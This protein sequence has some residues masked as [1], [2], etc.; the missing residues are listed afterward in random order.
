MGSIGLKEI[1]ATHDV[2]FVDLKGFY[3]MSFSILPHLVSTFHQPSGSAD[4]AESSDNLTKLGALPVWDLTDLY[5]SPQDPAID[6]DLHKARTLAQ[7]FETDYA[8]KLAI[9]G[10][11]K[12]ATALSLYE[13]ISERIDKVASFSQLCHAKQSDNAEIGAFYQKISEQSTDIWSH[14]LFFRLEINQLPEDVL[15]ALLEN[16]KVQAYRPWIEDVRLFRS[17]DLSPELEKLLM[18][19]NI[20]GAQAWVRL[21]DEHMAQLRFDFKGAQL[22]EAE[23]LNKLSSPEPETRKLAAYSLGKT[24][25]DHQH[26]FVRIYNSLIKD[27]AVEDNWRGYKRPVSSRNMANAVEDEVVD[28]LVT[29]VTNAYP[30][31]SHR[32]YRLKAKWFGQ[33]K[34]NYWDRNAP[35]PEADERLI[36][37]QDATKI[38]TTAYEEFSPKLADIAAPFFQNGWIDAPAIPGKASGA[39]AH[40]TVPSA[41]PYLLLNYQGKTRDVMTLAHELGHGV[42]QRLAAPQGHL[43]SDTPLTLAETAS[44]F[45]EMLTFRSLLQA[46]TDPGRRKILLA[47]K[48]EDMLN[49]VIRQI[50]MHQFETEAHAARAKGE[51]TPE[52]LGDIWI[53][54]QSESFGDG[55]QLDENYRHFWAY[56]PHFIHV[57]FYVYAYA[58]GD[59]LVNS[60][61]AVYQNS[62]SGFVDKYLDM[63]RAGG[64]KRH[65]DLLTPFGLNA[66]DPQFWQQG[67]SMI[68]GFID[69]L[70]ALE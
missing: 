29:S 63:L 14:L 17:Y 7:K 32:Y 50:A 59:C 23:I 65:H 51:L 53:K 16:P 45:G 21:F 39:F 61:Y 40:P 58:F 68:S 31:L 54:T 69:E 67:L 60:L 22:T 64:S 13:D 57:P 56:I 52:M 18:E 44:V 37:W 66:A 20:S 36:P 15:A 27:K 2:C 42:H 1:V 19:K 28:A 11:E 47:G 48:V 43:L 24:L 25:Q 33:E 35:L 26:I 46:E 8:Q 41:H 3:L 9:C 6:Q 49:T 55:I 62:E 5:L 4:S 34:L 70:E 12:F 10:P 38:V 30:S